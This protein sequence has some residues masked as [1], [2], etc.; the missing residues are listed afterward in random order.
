MMADGLDGSFFLKKSRQRPSA[1]QLRARGLA[2]KTI[3]LR[4][5]GIALDPETRSTVE[6]IALDRGR[7]HGRGRGR[8]G[9][10]KNKK[11]YL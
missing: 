5:E 6:G 1:G 10:E 4:V 3:P 2:T 8:G 7:D 9:G 11:I